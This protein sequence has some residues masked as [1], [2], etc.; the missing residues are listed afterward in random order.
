[1]AQIITIPNPLLREKSTEV[2]LNKKTLELVAELKKTLTDKEGQ[3]KGVGL[4]AVQIGVLQRVFIARSASSKK[5]LVFLNPEIT[6][7]SKR[8][9]V[10]VPGSKNKYEGCLSVPKLWAIVKR[11]S[12]IKIRYQTESGQLQIR[13]FSGLNA[14]II[15][16]EFD[17]LNGILFVD[18]ALEQNQKIYELVQDKEGKESL[19]EIRL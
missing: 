2:T 17:H 11:S 10:G 9:T 15:Q 3:I 7:Y 6:W 13:K 4:S 8:K 5:F 1:M 19:K 16:H 14:T 18:R 12:I